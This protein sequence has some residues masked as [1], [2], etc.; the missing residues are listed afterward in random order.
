MY[1]CMCVCVCVCMHACMYVCPL[2]PRSSQDMC[3]CTYIQA[4]LA[5]YQEAVELADGK[6]QSAPGK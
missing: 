5:L 6:F 1:T 4:A 2:P 3:T